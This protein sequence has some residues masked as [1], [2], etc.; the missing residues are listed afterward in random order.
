MGLSLSYDI[1]TKGHSGT[2]LVAT[3]VGQFTEF[4]IQIPIS[5]PVAVS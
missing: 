3:E 1:V 2:I 5:T 4:T